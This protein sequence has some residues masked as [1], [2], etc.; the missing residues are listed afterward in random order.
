MQ[1]VDL[2]QFQFDYDLT[3]A[4]LFLHPDG[5]VFARYGGRTRDGPMANNSIEG[6]TAT[7]D[8]V[9]EAY[10]GYPENRALFAS[11]RGPKPSLSTSRRARKR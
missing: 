9:L 1:G 5:T 11:K 8:R 3:W 2:E 4:A 7:M 10:K 6:L